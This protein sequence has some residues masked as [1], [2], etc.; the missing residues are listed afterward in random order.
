MKILAI[1]T[2]TSYLSV[3][4]ADGAKVVSSY[5]RQAYMSHSSRLIPAIDSVLTKAHMRLCDVDCLALGIGPGSFTGLR[6]GVTTIKG[7]AYIMK[8]P[9]V[10]VPTLDTIAH[11]VTDFA[12][13]VCPVLDAKKSKVYACLYESGRKGLKRISRYLLIEPDELMKRVCREMR[14]RAHK[15]LF[16]GDGIEVYGELFRAGGDGV[17]FLRGL[18]W[19]PRAGVVARLAARK[20][21]KK[22]FSD[23]CELVPLYLYSRECDMKGW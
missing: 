21:E 18:G 23:V 17:E 8:K 15:V 11:N 1:D 10:A 7:L 13:I 3:A 9:V 12:G 19:H 2:S 4:A 16:L 22:R 20:F 6:I 14:S 5:H